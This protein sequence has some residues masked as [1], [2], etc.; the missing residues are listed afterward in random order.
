MV[1]LEQVGVLELGSALGTLVAVVGPQRFRLWVVVD[2]E[3][4][5]KLRRGLGKLEFAIGP[6]A[7]YLKKKTTI[8]FSS[9]PANSVA[10]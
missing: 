7:F 4:S 6:G 5:L 3:V 10:S 1:A 9:F 2:P 8:F